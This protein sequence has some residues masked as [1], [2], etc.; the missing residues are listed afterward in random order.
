MQVSGNRPS[1]ASRQDRGSE[2]VRQR[3]AR[4][5]GAA[6]L[7]VLATNLGLGTPSLALPGLDVVAVLVVDAPGQS[8][9]VLHGT[10]P[11]PPGTFPREDGL[12]PLSILDHDG[13]IVPTQVELVSRYPREKDGADVVE[14]LG[15]VQVPPN[16]PAGTR[17]TYKVVDHVHTKTYMQAEASV[18]K[19]VNTPGSFMVVGKDCFGHQ[20]GTFVYTPGR[21]PFID[22]MATIMRNGAGAKTVRTY[23]V[24]L[25]TTTNL[26]APNG[27]LPHMFGVH[28]YLTGWAQEDVLTLD[29][30]INNG[31]SNNDKHNSMD[32]ILGDV[33]Y[34]SL[35]LWVPKGW[36]V[37]QQGP[38]PLFG[39]TSS[40]GSWTAFSIVEA[41][42]GGK[43][44]FFPSQGQFHRRFALCK[45]GNE[46]KA[47][48]FLDNKMLGFC[49]DGTSPTSGE[50]LWS[51]WNPKTARY[52]PQKHVLPNLD[53]VSLALKQ[54]AIDNVL[55]TV[56]ATLKSGTKP[57]SGMIATERL[58]YAQPWGAPYGG[59]TGGGEIFMFDG[60]ITADM[61]WQTGY[62][63]AALTHRTYQ[64]R[65]PDVLFNKDGDPTCVE[66]WLQPS[67]NG[68]H[69]NMNFYETLKP[70][71]DP[72]G[73]DEIDPF[74]VEF[75]AKQGLAPDYEAKL[76]SYQAIDLQHTIRTTR[77][78]KVLAWLGNDALAKDDLR[79]RAE[80][81]R[82]GFHQYNTNSGGSF[83]N[84]GVKGYTAFAKEHPG[85]G[86][87]IGRGQGWGL[88]TL[89]A[90]YS[91]SD[92]E[93][94]KELLP[95]Y[96]QLTDALAKGQ[97][98]CNGFVMSKAGPK[99][100]GGTYYAR[101]QY[102]CAILENAFRGVL[103]TVLRGVDA[104]R[105]AQMKDVIGTATLAMISPMSWDPVQNAP[106]SQLAVAP[107]EMTQP[108]FCGLP[109]APGGT[110]T[111]V[112][113]F[114]CWSSFAYGYALTKD[115]SLLTHAAD[116]AGGD[117]KLKMHSLGLNNL[118]N[119]A[120]LLAL[121]QQD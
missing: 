55:T 7:A 32:D 11:V 72:F 97:F 54:K 56:L 88:D 116:M 58:G 82:L 69:T 50:R 86:L 45:V 74:Q 73:F 46:A 31:P 84:V 61:G 23:G 10:V 75:V 60:L 42:P 40:Q 1:A 113:K 48:R 105:E 65:Q 43:L 107:L 37:L 93:Y 106:W 90:T 18:A 51:W 120:A 102:E 110:S 59:V 62:T 12:M 79:M 83:P 103:E 76:R 2:R 49:D 101:Q 34:E 89:N 47:Q 4:R 27:A 14:L 9:F 77:S 16:T 25:P 35:E 39:S 33:Y 63:L 71:P 24:M 92:E 96:Q 108:P 13:A 20:Y 53:H 6:L 41:L 36:T 28:S 29:L 64:D 81:F 67:P 17:L 95:F 68:P 21:K 38:D 15:R 114:Q 112:D 109:N 119:R 111:T 30:R 85:R 44:H 22:G 121:T 87:N 19:V 94:R 70:G 118:E 98:T 5:L 8:S 3:G 100:F 91:F 52:F 115:N 57:P 117:L 26:G 99:A 78:A 80:I 66:D 104:S